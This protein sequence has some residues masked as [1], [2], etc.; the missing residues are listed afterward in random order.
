[1]AARLPHGAAMR[2]G[3]AGA[4]IRGGI[5][6]VARISPQG[7]AAW[8]GAA[9]F[10]APRQA[11]STHAPGMRAG[12]S[13]PWARF[14]SGGPKGTKGEERMEKKDQDQYM[15]TKYHFDC[16]KVQPP[17]LAPRAS[18]LEIRQTMVPHIPKL[19]G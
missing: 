17:L 11:C 7:R 6:P 5:R 16:A 9:A 19:A 15:K 8:R 3:A 13:Q 14:M 18:A 12:A 10:E 2:I 1:M 4:A